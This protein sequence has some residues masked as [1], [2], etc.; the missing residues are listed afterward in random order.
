[1]K[2]YDVVKKQVK[3][4]YSRYQSSLDLLSGKKDKFGD[5]KLEF[6]KIEGEKKLVIQEIKSLH[7]KITGLREF[8]KRMIL[9]SLI[10]EA[11][12]FIS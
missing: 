2:E 4:F 8:E 10:S 7:E 12:R 11:S 6:E 9:A 5:V 1:M 3:E